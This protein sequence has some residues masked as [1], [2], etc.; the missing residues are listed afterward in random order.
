[1]IHGFSGL[2]WKYVIAAYDAVRAWEER[3]ETPA[4]QAAGAGDRARQV[5]LAPPRLRNYQLDEAGQELWEI[6]H[7]H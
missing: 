1:M 2:P 6:L 5:S 4:E 3:H 7:L